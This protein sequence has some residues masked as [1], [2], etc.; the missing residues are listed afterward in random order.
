MIPLSITNATSLR[1]AIARM[2]AG[3][4]LQPT[5]LTNQ[6]L[7]MAVGIDRVQVG[8]QVALRAGRQ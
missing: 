3:V 2:T 6:L 1:A 4:V 7:L 5:R 8:E